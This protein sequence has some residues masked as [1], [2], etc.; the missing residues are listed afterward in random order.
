M[1]SD[2]QSPLNLLYQKIESATTTHQKR[3]PCIG[4]SVNIKENQYCITDVYVKSVIKAGGTP[5]LIPVIEDVNSLIEVVDKLD[6]L[7]LSGGGDLHPSFF[8][9]ELDASPESINQERDVYDLTLI[10]LATDRQVPV[11]GICRGFQLLNV[12][13]GGTLYQDI[14]T[15]YPHTYLQ[16]SQT[17]PREEASQT[18]QV[19]KDSLLYKVIGGKEQ[20]AVNSFHHQAVKEVAP[21]FT[22]IAHAEDGIIE[23]FESN[24][25]HSVWGVQFHPECM[26]AT[27]NEEMLQIF[28][29]FVGEA[30]LYQQAKEIHQQIISIDSHTDTPMFFEQGIELNQRS[31]ILKEYANDPNSETMPLRVSINRMTEGKLDAVYM[32]AYLKQGERDKETTLKTV[33]KTKQRLKELQQQINKYAH[34]VGLAQTP[35]DIICLKK[36]GKKAVLM[37]VENAYG[38]GHDLHNL[39]L[40][41]DMGVTY[42]TLSHNGHNDIC[43]SASQEPEHNGLSSFGREVVQEMN[44]LGI[45]VDISHTSEKTS[46]DVLGI[47]KHPVIAS[48]SSAKAL[49]NH[50]RNVSDELMKAI[51]AKG[52]VIQICLYHAFLSAGS[53]ANILD[54]ANHID[55]IVKQ[56]GAD[57][58]GIGSDFDGGGG[59]T[60]IDAANEM[61]NLT[62]ELLRRGYTPVDIQKI[63]G[64]NLMRVMDCVQ[65][66]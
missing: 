45:M 57:H 51:A 16:H 56:V 66:I 31:A 6:G 53:T 49:C 30:G 25:H 15:H 63:W 7:I 36:E 55:Y 27:G 23:A 64:G 35:N 12:A 44:R 19:K 65:K 60:G 8:N 22:P 5:V 54:A 18:I 58:V 17:Q 43:D 2:S 14:A 47:S 3:K 34:Q 61:I 28:V 1:L 9:E 32:V 62:V 50:R 46:L 10:K 41:K 21:V 42:I 37:G 52:G 4:L 26:A 38:I 20:L 48:H 13:F 40:F 24:N 11:F 59:I 39:Q 33:E 29:H